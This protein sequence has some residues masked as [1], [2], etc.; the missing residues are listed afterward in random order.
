MPPLTFCRILILYRKRRLLIEKR[1]DIFVAADFGKALN[2][3]FINYLNYGV[4]RAV[5]ST[6]VQEDSARYIKS[7]II[8]KVLLR[9]LPSLTALEMC[10]N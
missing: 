10:K 6:D 3:E 2:L 1:N 4:I 8:D 9:D 7:D 5:L